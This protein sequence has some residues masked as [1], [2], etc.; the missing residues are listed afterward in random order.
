MERKKL[1]TQS[2]VSL[3]YE[4]YYKENEKPCLFFLHGL[5]GDLDAWQF[6]R[7][8]LL[9]KEFS[10]IAMDLRG[11]GYSDH[12]RHYQSYEIHHF[13]EDVHAILDAEDQKKCI[14]IGHCYGAIVAEHF[15]IKYPEKVER[16]I[17]I[18]STYKAPEYIKNKTLKNCARGLI[19]FGAALSPRAY[20]PR[21]AS[22]P[23]GKF[24]KDYEWGGLIKTMF[25]NSLRSYLLI[26]KEII[27]L[28]LEQ[29]LIKIQVPT[30]V[31]VGEK[32]SI[33]P[34]AISKKIQKQIQNSQLEIIKGAN[35]V[36][37]LNN[38][39]EIGE[40]V[41]KFLKKNSTFK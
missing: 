1:T 21:H 20:K 32:D 24:H 34:L 25:H 8:N 3:Y 2:G 5:G 29:E 14:L 28:D 39:S 16:L 26:S 33:F 22:Y 31:L 19:Y 9:T 37:I 30:L 27:N 7:E 40:A 23:K 17:L 11:H 6:L 38:A 10:G 36:V 41:K 18:S 4:T 12:P 35:H 15:A 13:C